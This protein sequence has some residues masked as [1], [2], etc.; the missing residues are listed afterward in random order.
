[1]VVCV[2]L[3]VGIYICCCVF[4]V[5]VLLCLSYVWS[6]VVGRMCLVVCVCLFVCL[7][8][9]WF[10]LQVFHEEAPPDEWLQLPGKAGKGPSR[11]ASVSIMLR[12]AL[13]PHNRARLMN[14][15]PSPIPVFHALST[16]FREV[17]ASHRFVLPTMDEVVACE[18]PT[19]SSV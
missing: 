17:L 8:P 4:V 9:D 11:P 12:T 18:T 3:Y 6:Y 15:T 19:L 14:S 16:A 1:V 10:A 7:F 2:R 5:V 13:F